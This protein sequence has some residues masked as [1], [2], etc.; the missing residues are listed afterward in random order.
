MIKKIF[1][2][3][4]FRMLTAL[5]YILLIFLIIS[6]S[7]VLFGWHW[8]IVL[9]FS[10]L[11]VL[12]AT[13][14]VK[15]IEEVRAIAFS[16][17]TFLQLVIYIYISLYVD[18][19]SIYSTSVLLF[20][21]IYYTLYLDGVSLLF[22]ILTNLVFFIV[23]LS[24][25]AYV[26][27][28]Y[29]QFMIQMSF[30]QW[31]LLQCFLS[32]NLL[33][34][35]IFFEAVLIP[36]FLLIGVW[37]SRRRKIYASYLF[38]MYT[39]TGSLI[40]LLA[41]CYIA[42]ICPTLLWVDLLSL[43]PNL[44]FFFE[45]LLFCCFFLAFAIKAPMFPFHLWLP[46]AH[47]EAP[48]LGSVI[49]AGI[50]LKLGGYG[51]LRFLIPIFPNA[52]AAYSYFIYLICLISVLYSALIGL[53]QLDMKKIIA[54]SSITHMNFSIAGLF[55]NDLLGVQGA[56]YS[57]F[58]HGLI[59][60]GLFMCVGVLYDRYKTRLLGYYSG[61][62]VGMPL[63][64]VLFFLLVIANVGIPP[65]SGFLSEIIVLFGLISV[66]KILVMLLFL[67]SIFMTI[68]FFWFFNRICCGPLTRSSILLKDL[69][70]DEF[71]PLFILIFGSFIFGLFP[72][73][74]FMFTSEFVENV[75]L[76]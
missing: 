24:S 8:L 64:T 28:N 52:S 15:T 31:F 17:G 46:E 51:M 3:L 58:S 26:K 6:F 5:G 33:F 27:V 49:L 42:T 44:S 53:C 48:T 69:S 20:E 32:A 61:L 22:M 18:Y 73:Y 23:Y 62:G 70:V 38:F 66:N 14:C 4:S 75:V 71:V 37:G 72:N 12:Y 56:I 29:L 30:L 68:N 7:L 35:Y 25:R 60:S 55:S 19:T 40:M 74:I 50:L 43:Y 9:S 36:M 65:F 59:S 41:I 1:D 10:P 57:M 2:P 76:Y 21:D 67:S 63:F 39:L 34:F 13:F 54:Y 45:S 11:L 16:F 47:V